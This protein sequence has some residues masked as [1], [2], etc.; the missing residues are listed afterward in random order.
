MELYND[1]C[2]SDNSAIRCSPIALFTYNKSLEEMKLI[3]ELSTKITHSQDWAVIGAMQQC[4]AIREALNHSKLS[5]DSFDLDVFYMKIVDFVVDL[6]EN[7]KLSDKINYENLENLPVSLKKNFL[8]YLNQKTQMLNCRNNSSNYKNLELTDNYLIKD[9]INEYLKEIETT[10]SNDSYSK[11]LKKLHKI[12]KRCRRGAKINIESLYKQVGKYNCLSS[13]QSIPIALFTFM[14][15]V[16]PRCKHELNIKLMDSKEIDSF[17]EYN[18][19]ERVILY[20]ISYG[21]DTDTV[22]SMAGAIAGA[23]SLENEDFPYYLGR[24]N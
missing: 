2:L 18:S 4:Y 19:I 15:A 13:I 12:I 23:Y 14:I 8:L 16:D 11:L 6:E 3:C 1:I 9:Y 17:K 22:C 10:K 24:S 5:I 20:A 21:G 7:Y